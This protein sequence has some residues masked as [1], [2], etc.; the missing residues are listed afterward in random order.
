MTMSPII[1]SSHNCGVLSVADGSRDRTGTNSWLERSSVSAPPTAIRLVE[2]K[3]AVPFCKAAVTWASTMRMS[4]ASSRS[5][6]S[7]R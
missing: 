7:S 3:K 6:H 2:A 5:I 1:F 4:R